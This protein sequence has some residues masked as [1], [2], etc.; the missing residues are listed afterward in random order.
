MVVSFRVRK[1]SQST[2]KLARTPILIIIKKL[3]QLCFMSRKD[4]RILF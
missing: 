3:A 1:I 2:R 4:A